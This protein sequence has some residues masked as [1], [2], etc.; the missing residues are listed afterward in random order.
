MIENNE[1]LKVEIE[2]N[3][4]EDF[5]N[6]YEVNY[7]E[8]DELHFLHFEDD[9]DTKIINFSGT[10]NLDDL[11]SNHEKLFDSI[12]QGTLINFFYKYDKYLEFPVPSDIVESLKED[13]F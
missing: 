10:R 2:I 5:G 9:G 11:K 4:Y 1:K 8:D 3:E 12:S 6:M 13:N 7:S